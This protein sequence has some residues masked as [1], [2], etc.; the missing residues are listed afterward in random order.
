[1]HAGLLDLNKALAVTPVASCR[2]LSFKG[3]AK[4][5]QRK[6]NKMSKVGM[7]VL[8]VSYSTI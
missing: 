2:Y 3:S 8:H 7:S 4:Q 1:M 6:E 5:K